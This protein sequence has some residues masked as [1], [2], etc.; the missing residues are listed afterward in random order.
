MNQLYKRSLIWSE[1]CRKIVFFLNNANIQILQ[2]QYFRDFIDFYFKIDKE[3]YNFK[4][5]LR[6]DPYIFN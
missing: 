5:Y 6:K 4:N 2:Q 1:F 3:L